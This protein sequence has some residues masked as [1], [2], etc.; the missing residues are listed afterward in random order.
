M[1]RFLN[2]SCQSTKNSGG[3]AER[4]G[5]FRKYPHTERGHAA[6]RIRTTT[7]ATYLTI[8]FAGRLGGSISG[9]SWKLREDIL[10][11]GCLTLED[12]VRSELVEIDTRPFPENIHKEGSAKSSTS[13]GF[14]RYP[15]SVMPRLSFFGSRRFNSKHVTDYI[16]DDG[17]CFL[18]HIDATC[19]FCSKVYVY[20]YT[21]TRRTQPTGYYHPIVQFR[22]LCSRGLN[23]VGNRQRNLPSQ[24]GCCQPDIFLCT[25]RKQAFRSVVNNA[26]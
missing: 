21:Y 3:S 14:S 10:R 17:A 12:D 1:L 15:V 8:F 13:S 23:S 5:H 11:Q 7:Y 22:K 24:P 20:T 18:R 16:Y 26:Q 4:S 19:N 9:L 25:Y 6:E 2:F